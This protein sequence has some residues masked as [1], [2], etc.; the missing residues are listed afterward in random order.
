MLLPVEV[1]VKESSQ[2]VAADNAPD[3]DILPRL[4]AGDSN[5]GNMLRTIDALSVRTSRGLAFAGRGPRPS[6]G[7][8]ASRWRPKVSRPV[9]TFNALPPIARPSGLPFSFIHSLMRRCSSA[10]PMLLIM[11]AR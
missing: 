1:P 10:E 11:F 2:H 8:T 5:G 9:P 7:H 3:I 6:Y 4:K